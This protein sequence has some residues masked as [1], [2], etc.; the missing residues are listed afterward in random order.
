MFLP[1]S[2]LVELPYK[3]PPNDWKSELTGIEVVPSVAGRIAPDG[4]AFVKIMAG[5]TNDQLRQWCFDHKTWCMP[6]NVIMVEVS[7][8]APNTRLRVAPRFYARAF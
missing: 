3:Q 1:Y 4:H 7:A 2:T 6:C 5:T 8:F